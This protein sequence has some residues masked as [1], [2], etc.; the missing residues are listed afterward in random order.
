M[1]KTETATKDQIA[2]TK[3]MVVDDDAMVRNIIVEYLRR[4][5]FS[6]IFEAKNGEIALK[7]LREGANFDLIISD[8]EMPKVN[9]LTLL[10]A[11]KGGVGNGKAKFVMITS[12]IS[13]E[14]FKVSRA[15][16]LKVDG[17][18]VKPFKGDVL[19]QHIFTAMGWATNDGT[20]SAAK[21]AG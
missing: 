2:L 10:R 3:V 19:K 17:Y 18:V 6:D 7:K 13:Q 14:R 5:G 15:I 21:K 4:F 20:P 12:Q 8:W 1:S 16:H 9:G 11:V